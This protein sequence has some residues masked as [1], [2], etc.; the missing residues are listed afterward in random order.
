MADEGEVILPLDLIHKA[1]LVLT[2]ALIALHQEP[3]TLE[4]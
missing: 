1:K 4:N 2:D 3:H